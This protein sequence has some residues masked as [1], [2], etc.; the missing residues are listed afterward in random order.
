MVFFQ[1][2]C[3][4]FL[5]FFPKYLVV[6]LKKKK[7]LH[8]RLAMAV[9]HSTLLPSGSEQDQVLRGSSIPKEYFVIGELGVKDVLKVVRVVCY[10]SIET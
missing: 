9:Q 10:G 2:D 6:Y 3:S 4:I 1:I 5:Y 8:F 7:K